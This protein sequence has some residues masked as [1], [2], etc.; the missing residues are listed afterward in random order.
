MPTS[1]FSRQRSRQANLCVMG[2]PD[3]TG[4]ASQSSAWVSARKTSLLY[5]QMVMG[6]FEII[7]L[8]EMTFC[9]RQHCGIVCSVVGRRRSEIYQTLEIPSIVKAT[10]NERTETII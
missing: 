2:R 1:E 8:Y 7:K 3:L 5:N 9:A 4:G 6:L 10:P